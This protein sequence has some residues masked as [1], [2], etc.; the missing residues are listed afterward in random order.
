[1]F[2]HESSLDSDSSKEPISGTI[3]DK[4]CLVVPIFLDFEQ[5]KFI[6]FLIIYGIA[7]YVNS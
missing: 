6:S 3:S 7:I 5:K 4:L 2:M 1:M